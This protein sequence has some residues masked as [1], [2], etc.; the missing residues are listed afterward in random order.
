MVNNFQD[1]MYVL[2]SLRFC[3]ILLLCH[4]TCR[5]Q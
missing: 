2:S 4:A 5:N 1:I 3:C